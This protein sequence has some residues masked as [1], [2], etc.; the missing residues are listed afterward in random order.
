MKRANR[1]GG[2]ARRRVSAAM[3]H[4]SQRHVDTSKARRSNP[5]AVVGVLPVEKELFVESAQPLK[6]VAAGHQASAGNPIHIEW[7]ARVD[8][9]Q[10]TLRKPVPRKMAGQPRR[11][12]AKPGRQIRESPRGRLHGAIGVEYAGPRDARIGVRCKP[13]LENPNDRPFDHR[14]GIQEKKVRC[15]RLRGGKVDAGGEA[16][17]VGSRHG[18]DANRFAGDLNRL[19][20]RRSIA[21]VVNHDD[22]VGGTEMGDNRLETLREVAIGSIV[23]D[24]NSGRQ[25][26][27][28]ASRQFVRCRTV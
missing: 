10:V 1:G 13:R 20:Q 26:E 4:R 9:N 17:I 27:I 25:C 24:E 5:V 15:V 19:N 18:D 23:D 21:L 22:L 14:V 3:P 8:T 16:E 11:P 2:I 12:T 28:I 6:D 7:R